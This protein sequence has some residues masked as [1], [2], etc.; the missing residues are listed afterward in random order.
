MAGFIQI[1]PASMSARM[2]QW[3]PNYRQ[4]IELDSRTYAL[5]NSL[6]GP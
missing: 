5:C 1:D 4:N 3:Q 2:L 6:P